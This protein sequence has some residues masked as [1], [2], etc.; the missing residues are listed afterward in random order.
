MLFVVFKVSGIEY[1]IEARQVVE[2]I[3]LVTLRKC[4]GSP[5]YLAGLANYGG[6]G[7]PVVDLGRLV[8]GLSCVTYLSTRIIVMDYAGNGGRQRR[9]GLLAESVTNTVE[10]AE[11]DFCQDGVGLQGSLGQGKLAVNGAGFVQRVVAA[12][13][14]PREVEAELF[15]ELA[16]EGV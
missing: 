16:E 6:V 14:L 7:L 9:I 15:A 8:G 1:A 3:P 2:V 12:N 11:S 5:A 4:P 13:L 10:R